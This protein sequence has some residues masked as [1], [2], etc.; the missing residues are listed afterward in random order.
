MIGSLIIKHLS[1]L[2]DRETVEQIRENTYMQYF[3]GYSSFTTAQPFDSTLFVEFRKRLGMDNLNAINDKIIA[4]K[5]KLDAS[6]ADSKPSGTDQ[7]PTDHN[8]GSENRG[9][10][11]FDVTA[12]PQDIAY[13]TDLNLLSDAREKAEQLID[14]LYD[15]ELHEK[16]P[17]T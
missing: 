11:I 12:C 6:T 15:P 7:D 1:N 2:D 5:T 17:R 4:L 8:S 10:V 14:T 3:H 16:K 13:P 9:R